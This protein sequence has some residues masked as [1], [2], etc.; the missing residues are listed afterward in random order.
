MLTLQYQ[1][2]ALKVPEGT[3]VG[4]VWESVKETAPDAVFALVDGQTLDFT[5]ALENN[6]VISFETLQSAVGNRAYQRTLIML[7]AMAV[8]ELY[9]DARVQIEHSLGRALYGQIIQ[10]R[11][12]T[13]SQIQKIEDR[14]HEIVQEGRPI[15]K[16]TE[17]KEEAIAYCRKVGRLR[18]VERLQ[19]LRPER[20]YLYRCGDYVDFYFGPLL[21]GMNRVNVF[22]IIHYAPGFLLRFPSIYSAHTLPEYVELREFSRVFF[23]ATSWS[24][25]VGCRYVVDLNRAIADGRIKDIIAMAEARHEKQLAQIADRVA[26]SRPGIRLITIAGPSSAGKTTTMRRLMVQMQVNGIQPVMISLDDYFYS[27]D[28]RPRTEN[29][30]IDHESVD[31]L[32]TTLLERQLT[33]LLAGEPVKLS[34]YDFVHGKQYF[35]EQETTLPPNQPI[36]LEGLH[37]LN[38]S[39]SRAVPAYQR[40]HLYLGALTQLTISDH[41]RISTTD[42]RLLRRLVRDN[43][44]R[45]HSA[46]ETLKIWRNVRFGEESYIFPFQEEADIIFNTALLYELP[47]LKVLAEPLLKAIPN[48]SPVANEAHRLLEFLSIFQPLNPAMVPSNSILREFI[49]TAGHDQCVPRTLMV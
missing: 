37:A 47:V 24:E 43:Q 21:Q 42:T 30:E 13:L 7:M 31:A 27:L 10:N 35:A 17:S 25:Q 46:E 33:A 8:Q 2:Q 39:V 11:P 14:M 16:Q 34:R 3:T 38:P 23:E 1:G 6:A 41:N 22:D 40:L 26:A 15:I 32:D 12:T 19:E 18:A 36:I 5:T 29:D 28:D 48:T 9:P 45:A 49:G 20:I 4:T 44:F